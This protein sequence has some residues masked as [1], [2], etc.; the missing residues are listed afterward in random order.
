M[1]EVQISRM[2]ARR[3]GR[4]LARASSDAPIAYSALNGIVGTAQ[5]PGIRCRVDAASYSGSASS[6]ILRSSNLFA[7]KLD[8]QFDEVAVAKFDGGRRTALRHDDPS[9]C[10]FVPRDTEFVTERKGAVEGRYFLFEFDAAV[11]T[12]VFGHGLRNHDFRPHFGASPMATDIVRRFAAVCGTAID[13]P[14]T[15]VEALGNLMLVD[16]YRTF[17]SQPLPPLPSTHIGTTRFKT[18]LDYIDSAL[19]EDISLHF[20]AQL[21][22]LSSSHFSHAFKSKYGVAPYHYILQRRVMRAKS[23]L[24]LTDDT[25]AEIAVD[26]GFSSQS[27]FS[28]VFSRHT[29]FT[30]SAYRSS[31]R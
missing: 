23:L 18:V 29:G 24:R 8:G 10:I 6:N 31:T 13:V 26:V 22:G 12:L 1:K 19:D 7:C 25:V 28:V 15:Y 2:T 4:V 14:L 20:L 16:L 21:V 27:R 30:P 3:T 11:L 5:M 17:G 9:H